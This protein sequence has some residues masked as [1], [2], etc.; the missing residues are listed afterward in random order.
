MCSEV[1]ICFSIIGEQEH[2]SCQSYLEIDTLVEKI[3]YFFILLFAI[4]PCNKDL[5]PDAEAERHHEDDHVEYTGYGGCT[6]FNLAYTPQ[7]G[8]VRHAYHLFHNQTDKD[9]VGNEPYFFVGIL[10]LHIISYSL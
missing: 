10:G 6:Y 5:C 8:S 9:G 2:D 3:A 4:A 7:K 1:T